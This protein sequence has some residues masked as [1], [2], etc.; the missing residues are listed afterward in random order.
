VR[1]PPHAGGFSL[2]SKAVDL[3]MMFLAALSSA[4]SL[5]AESSSAQVAMLTRSAYTI[6]RRPISL[7][8]YSVIA[9]LN[10]VRPK[11]IGIHA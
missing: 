4:I 10:A 2:T 8:T 5:T 7:T 1:A 3:R 9:G 11:Q 6:H